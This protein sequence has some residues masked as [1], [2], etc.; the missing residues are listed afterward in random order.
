MKWIVRS[1]SML[2][3]CAACQMTVF[4]AQDDGPGLEG[5]WN[6]SASVHD[7]QTGALI[8]QVRVMT[9]FIHDGSLTQTAA[10]LVR[11]SAEGRWRHAEGHTFAVSFW[12][13]RY[14]PDGSF[15]SLANAT[16]AIQLSHDGTQFT[17]T[18]LVRDFDGSDRLIS[19]G[20]VTE[21]ATRLP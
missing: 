10:N 13:F 18:G 12:F 1:C 15:A 6:V 4:A 20:C 14:N 11:S 7:C 19:T 8:R 2:A 16:N 17:S 9:M 5:V 3:L 21:T